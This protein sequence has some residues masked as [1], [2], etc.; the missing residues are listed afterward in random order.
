MNITVS[1]LKTLNYSAFFNY[2]LSLNEVYKY[3]IGDKAYSL[4]QVKNE[5]ARLVTKK[6][7]QKRGNLYAL[8]KINKNHIKAKKNSQKLYKRAV[9]KTTKDLQFLK[10]LPFVKFVGITGSVAAKNIKEGGDIDLFIIT[11]KN[12]VWL[13]RLLFVIFLKFTKRYKVVYCPNIYTSLNALSWDTKNIYVANEIVR[14]TPIFNKNKTYEK[15]LVKNSWV[16]NYL[17]NFKYYIPKFNLNFKTNFLFN[18]FMPV[19][20]LLF[21]LQYFYMRPKITTELVCKDKILFL[22]NDYTS[23]ILHANP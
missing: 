10:N 23:K 11:D 22:K 20:Y 1:V 6:K 4:S 5:L 7:V 13:T 2:P 12:F 17:P 8:F 9:V 18:L 3:L 19:N 16:C 14:I 21:K 15:F